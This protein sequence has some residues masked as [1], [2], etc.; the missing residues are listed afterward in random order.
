LTVLIQSIGW[1]ESLQWVAIVGLLLLILI[2][3][4]VK[5]APKQYRYAH[6]QSEKGVKQ[7]GMLE[8]L[9]LLV[10]NRMN[11]LIGLYICTMNLPI[12]ILAG[13]FGT[14]YMAQARGFNNVQA[15]TISMM[16]F[17]G[18]IVG[19]SLFG[20]LSDYWGSRRKP[21]LITAVLALLLFVFIMYAPQMS[22]MAYLVLFFILGLITSGQVIGYP[23]ARECNPGELMGSA[24][25]FVSIIILG[26]P[27]LLQPLVGYLMSF[28]WHGKIVQGVM[29]YS[30]HAYNVG[31]WVLVIGFMI[32]VVCAYGMRETFQAS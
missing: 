2:V 30:L 24:L 22:Y 29:I 7:Y 17:I 5:D 21:M 11:W 3:V 4:V 15:S 16:I 14:Q 10:R 28:E 26:L 27:G 32:S 6:L 9:L 1:R 19:S 13:L 12:M 31:L 23:T 8:A 25:G 18:T 20:I